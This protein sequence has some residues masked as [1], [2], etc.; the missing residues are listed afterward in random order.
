ML[1]KNSKKKTRKIDTLIGRKRKW[2]AISIL[3]AACM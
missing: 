1:G 2:P 3:A